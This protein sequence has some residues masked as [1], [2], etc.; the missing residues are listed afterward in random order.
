[1]E[2]DRYST[3]LA[4]Q[5]LWLAARAEGIGVGWVSF[6]Y[7]HEVRDVLNI[8]HHIQPIAYLCVGYPEDGFPD[9][10]VLQKQGWRERIDGDELVHYG[11]WNHTQTPA[12][13][14]HDCVS[15]DD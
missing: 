1:Q 13:Q 14:P 6:L 9:E 8:P 12:K 10:P 3:C 7:P 4:V 11:E 15:V 5:N 2:M